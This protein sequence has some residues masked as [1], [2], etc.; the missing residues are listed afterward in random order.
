MADFVAVLK[1]TIGGLSSNTPEMREKVYQRARDTVQAKLA[2]MQPP[3][4]PIVVERQKK[5]LEAAISAV[6]SSYAKDTEPEDEFAAIFSGMEKSE[7]ETAEPAQPVEAETTETAADEEADHVDASEATEAEVSPAMPKAVELP[8]ADESDEEQELT[9]V[10]AKTKPEPLLAGSRP[11]ANDG[12]RQPAAEKKPGQ[13]RRRIGGG[14]IAAA[15]A[16]LV[17]AAAGY[18]IWLNRD[19]FVA[20]FSPTEDIASAPETED[21]AP[22]GEESA[23][24]AL[25]AEEASATE[26][27]EQQAAFPEE[28]AAGEAPA[29]ENQSATAGEEQEKFTQRLTAEGEEVDPGP[30]GGDPS[31]GEGTSVATATQ[32]GDQSAGTQ[33][34]GGTSAG[35]G[36][37]EALPV[38]QRAIFYEERTTVSDSTAETGS[39]VWS[40]VQESPGGDLPPE[41]AIRAEVNIPAKGLE[42]RMTIRRNADASLPASHIIEMIFLTEENFEGGGIEN[43]LRV[44]FKPSEAAPGNPLIGIPAKIADGYFLI[45]LSNVEDERDLNLQLMRR[46]SWIDIPIVYGSGR[47]ALVTMERGVPGD[48]AFID[49]LETWEN[50]SNGQSSAAAGETAGN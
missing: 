34:S 15:V 25:A 21:A 6:E 46:Q 4:S 12:E 35:S 3:P 37:G 33:G 27:P 24:E 40:V 20:L 9:P 18:G 23:G 13:R 42:L 32:P 48:R 45:A 39:T 5:A 41:P 50:L 1:K 49:V 22:A 29:G 17:V 2:A 43:V 30:A 8:A 19:A 7:P 28:P 26:E 10:E 44:A 38:G 31:I 16:L 36:N 11:A 14:I 47:R